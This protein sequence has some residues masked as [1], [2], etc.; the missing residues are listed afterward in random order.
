M[1]PESYRWIEKNA[2]EE[3]VRELVRQTGFPEEFARLLA[4]RGV[5]SARE[6]DDFLNP[7][8]E[9]M[10]D[11]FMMK[12]MRAAAERVAKAL[13]G[14]EK[15]CIYGD[16]DVDGIT[17]TSIL[18]LFMRE[19][20]R[21]RRGKEDTADLLSYYLPDR[22][23]EGYG[24][25]PEAVR[26]IASR[27]T[28][29]IVTVDTGIT[30]VREAELAGRLGLDLVITDHHECL[31]TLPRAA[32]LVDARQKGETYPFPYLAGC[33]VAFKLVQALSSLLDWQEDI[34]KYLELAAV[35]TVADIVSLTG[36]NRIIVSEGFRRMRDPQIMGLRKLLASAGYDF[37]RKL[38]SGFIGFSAAPR[39]NA[40]GRMGDASRG[41]VLFTT[42][43]EKLAESIAGELDQENTRR[44][45]TEQDILDQVIR[46]IEEDPAK[47]ESRFIIAAGK[48]WHS[49]VVGIVSSR[50]KDLYYRPNII[51]SIKEDGT[52]VGSA[53][54]IPGFD[55]FKALCS[56]Q[57]LFIKFGGH[58]AA[59]GMSLEADKLPLLEKRLNEYAADHMEGGLLIPRLETELD[60]DVSDVTTDLV[61]L[62]GKMEPFGMGMPQPL[63][64]VHGILDE[65]RAVGADGKTLRM[66][67]EGRG[68]AP[69]RRYPARITAV[70]FRRSQLADYYTGG[71]AVMAAGSLS[72]DSYQGHEYPQ[73]IAQDLHLDL[74]ERLRDIMFYFSLRRIDPSYER[75]CLTK[76]SLEPSVCASSYR[77]LREIS[78]RQGSP[79]RGHISLED[80]TGARGEKGEEALY[81]LLQSLCV[82]EELGLAGLE[83]SGP[84]LSFELVPGKKA[85]LADSAW[86][87]RFFA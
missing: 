8:P 43:D 29:L 84:Y 16:Y 76:E 30:A 87:R 49:G 5:K 40:G 77:M 68:A 53:R 83:C 24:M 81:R 57:D 36:E 82:F 65:I 41:V 50:I 64:R 62:I 35:G 3:V 70:A 21:K 14:G 67:I 4:A 10:H 54:S 42:D 58:A 66:R 63:V 55:I 59:A 52:A 38:T 73:I 31:E 28:K 71:M 39:L 44:K 61:K 2:D 11:P 80:Y 45:E 7:V 6:A 75:Y 20:I 17:A 51:F 25:N 72:I 48:E 69:G 74:D 15:I 22:M 12:G 19:Y 46:Q 85:L 27:G 47:R 9:R 18:Y 32:A 37:K 23:T 34:L 1:V 26:Q 79:G 86:Y 60:L 33:G 56:C 78:G 13:T